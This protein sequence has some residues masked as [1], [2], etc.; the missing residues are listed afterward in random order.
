VNLQQ[1]S[2]PLKKKWGW[3]G[4]L[5][6]LSSIL[7]ALAVLAI[8]FFDTP[9]LKTLTG[10]KQSNWNMLQDPRRPLYNLFQPDAGQNVI[11][12]SQIRHIFSL[13]QTHHMTTYRL[14]TGLSQDVLT[15]QR[16][17]EG[18]WPVKMVAT[19]P[20]LLCDPQEIKDY[21]NCTV[22]DRKEDVALEYCY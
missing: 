15:L 6:L 5:H 20:Y 14:S 22:V 13:L 17:I 1:P 16:I 7:L 21:P 12:S 11:F 2:E 9:V 18:T 8:V 3:Q 4:T 19:S 10:L